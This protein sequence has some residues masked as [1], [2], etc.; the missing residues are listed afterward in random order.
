MPWAHIL[1]KYCS[2]SGVKE[3]S[4]TGLKTGKS[5][6]VAVLYSSKE[7]TVVVPWMHPEKAGYRLIQAA[8]VTFSYRVFTLLTLS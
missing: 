5:L 2:V 7:Q 3:L 8:L 1:R 4:V 6:K